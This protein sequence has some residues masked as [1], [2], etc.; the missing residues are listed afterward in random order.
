MSPK[1]KV[2]YT[3]LTLVGV[4]SLGWA[5]FGPSGMKEVT[6]LKEETARVKAEVRQL[7]DKK[8]VLAKQTEL[9]RNDPRLIERRARDTLGMVKSDET[10]IMVPGAKRN[11]D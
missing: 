11:G 9:M 5:L 8:Q 4:L 6:R 3:I 7:E 1:E 2:L 10:V